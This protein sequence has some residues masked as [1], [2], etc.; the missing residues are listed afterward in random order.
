[1]KAKVIISSVKDVWKCFAMEKYLL[2][3]IEKHEII[4]YLWQAEKNVMLGKNQNPWRECNVGL[5]EK[6]GGKL[7][8][9]I[10]G[11]GTIYCDLG[12]MLFSFIVPNEYYNVDCQLKVIMDACEKLGVRVERSGRNDIIS[13]GKK[14]SGNAFFHNSRVSL[15]HGSLLVNESIDNL[16]RYLTPSVEKIQSKGIQ[17]VRSR[18][19]NLNELSPLV[20]VASLKSSIIESFINNYDFDSIEYIYDDDWVNCYEI[21]VNH[22]LY[23]SWDWVYGKAMDTDLILEKR[24]SWGEVQLNFKLLESKIIECIVFSDALDID[25]IAGL[26][27]QFE[28]IPFNKKAFANAIQN[29][30][31]NPA[32][33]DYSQ[34]ILNWLLEID[35]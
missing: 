31:D 22:E 34:E 12:S 6:E 3:K 26:K 32:R 25:Y 17:S 10:T 11:G 8:R 28:G 7:A 9:R 21:N 24:F 15:H 35:I 13:Q 23:K 29:Y 4:L 20:N 18:V 30:G 19:I 5:L 16:V 33:R 1:M 14:F 2:D 27:S